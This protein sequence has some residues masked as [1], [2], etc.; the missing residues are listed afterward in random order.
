MAQHDY[1]IANQ[2]F[3][4]FRTDVNNVLS[5]INSSNSGSSRPSSAVAGTIWLDTSG[6]ATAQLLKMYDGAA[7]ILLGTVNFTA[8]TI[9]WSDSSVTIPDNSVTL[10]KMA[11][12]TDGNIISY[13]ASGDPVAVATG[14]AGQVLTS[15]GAGAVPTFA[16]ATVPDNA[17]TLAKMASGTDGNIISYDASGNPVAVATGSSGQVLTSAGAGAVPSFQAAAGGG[18]LL[19]VVSVT[20]KDAFSSTASNGTFAAITG[21]SAAITPSATSSKIL[22]T[23]MLNTSGSVYGQYI[24][25]LKG[26]STI[27]GALGT[28]SGSRTAIT[29]YAGTPDDA[30]EMDTCH[31]NYLDS[32]S[33]TSAVTYSLS[34]SARASTTWTVNYPYEDTDYDYS[35]HSVSTITLMEIGA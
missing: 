15:A 19:Q 27:A 30:A 21:A 13:D 28:V 33:S 9:D 18:K 31:I 29:A 8:N 35:G 10:A 1:D 32:P 17:I 34:G 3:P 26:G 20:W 14:S 7:D 25:L 16:T 5:A 22:V 24:R 11:S 2:S 23:A 6:A 4:A 12:G